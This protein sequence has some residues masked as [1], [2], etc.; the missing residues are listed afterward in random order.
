MRV[1]IMPPSKL[2]VTRYL[3]PK[4]VCLL[5]GVLSRGGIISHLSLSLS[6]SLSLYT[7]IYIYIYINIHDIITLYYII[8]ETNNTYAMCC[9]SP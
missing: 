8:L 7:Y 5:L 2:I 1:V 3:S 6:I 4:V 9:V